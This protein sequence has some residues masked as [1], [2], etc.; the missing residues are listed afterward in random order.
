M[1]EAP[2]PDEGNLLRTP[3]RTP[4][5]PTDIDGLRAVSPLP[6][7]PAL[8]TGSRHRA[9]ALDEARLSQI[10]HL[11][12][13]ISRLRREKGQL[14]ER[15]NETLKNNRTMEA[16]LGEVS[17]QISAWR[18]RVNR[19][20]HVQFWTLYQRLSSVYPN[21]E[22][23]AAAVN[24]DPSR[25]LAMALL[26]ELQEAGL[27]PG[28]LRHAQQ[29]IELFDPI[30][31]LGEYTDIAE[32]RLNPLLH[33]VVVGADQQRR[34]NLLFDP[35]YYR[36]QAGAFHGDPLLHYIC[37]GAQTGLQPHP[38]FDGRYYSKNSEL[39]TGVN[40]LFDYQIWG[41]REGRDPCRLF[42]TAYFL[43]QMAD[44]P[45]LTDNPL[46][47]YLLVGPEAPNPHPL[48]AN[49]WVGGQLST[50]RR[51]AAPLVVYETEPALWN[52]L[53][54]HPLFDVDYLR[55]TAGVVFPDNCS[56]L[57]HFCRLVEREDV[58]PTIL[59]DSCLYRYQ[60]EVERKQVI[61][62]APILH[63]LKH[64]Y[65]D[66][67]LR[68]NPLFDP[69]VYLQRNQIEVAEP[70]LVHYCLVGDRNGY[71][72]HELFS[73]GT[74]NAARMDD[75]PIT[76]LEHFLSADAESLVESHP[77]LSRPLDR[78]PLQFAAA[79][80]RQKRDFDPDFYRH[81]YPDLAALS[82]AD[83]EIHYR[84]AGKGQGRYGSERDL[85]NRLSLRIADVP[86][87]FFPDE[88][89]RI[90]PDLMEYFGLK[91]FPL[92]SHYLESGRFE[93]RKIGTWQFHIESLQLE[94]P[95]SAV[96]LRLEQAN[97]RQEVCVL[98][99]I[100]YPDLWPELAAFANNFGGTAHDIYVNVV[101]IA[102]SLR[103]Q[104][105]IRELCPAAFV[106]LSNDNGRDIG[107]FVRLLDNID[108]EKYEFFAFMHSKKSPH[109]ASEQGAYW[110]RMLLNAFCGSRETVAQCISLFHEDPSVGLIATKNWRATDLSNNA[111]HYQRLL[112][113]FGVKEEHRDPEYVS[114]TM[115]L[116][117]SDIVR[118]LYD[119]LKS[120]EFEYGGDKDLDFHMDGQIA[121]GVERIIGNLVRDMGYRIHW[122]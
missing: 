79:A 46:H 20:R 18:R 7:R 11:Q 32:S 96:P 114:G 48:F 13:Q 55:G 6:L 62:E 72:T 90:N 70:E 4:K 39:N 21:F 83:A 105:E 121:H 102:W 71:Y 80:T 60:L 87:G 92:F 43:E 12:R 68:P 91:F 45:L 85:I 56:P 40:P 94:V 122:N 104:E 109:I 78:R 16:H 67:S 84:T 61:D 50:A 5:R 38:L 106:Q 28:I 15:L 66:K 98:I 116:I 25:I 117:R 74:Y 33:Y 97:A 47:D 103:F 112:D 23:Y 118:R 119:G 95:T 57:N 54:P 89:L 49:R 76:A 17:G 26:A 59:F 81:H 93:N 9:D 10:A 14:E 1:M 58:D 41:C 64:G 35:N 31:Y 34:P 19:D 107:G 115:F 75:E 37:S 110:R 27:A 22:A 8:G 113:R 100:F 44:H 65:R 53:N 51:Q 101:D 82:D 29:I 63:Y 69:Q 24:D 111:G 2:V 120:I 108:T 3:K 99:H 30:F 42:D 88:Y 77:H 52:A 86:L 73:A 36:R